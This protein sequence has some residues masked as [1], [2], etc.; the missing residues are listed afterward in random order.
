MTQQLQF[1][2]ST[3]TLQGNLVQTRVCTSA[4]VRPMLRNYIADI[5]RISRCSSWRV[6]TPVIYLRNGRIHL[7]CNV[8]SRV[9][10]AGQIKWAV[11]PSIIHKHAS[12][13]NLK[14]IPHSDTIA[15]LQH[16]C[17]SLTLRV[18]SFLIYFNFRNN[19][20]RISL[21]SSVLGSISKW[22]CEGQGEAMCS[23]MLPRHVR[24]GEERLIKVGSTGGHCVCNHV[25]RWGGSMQTWSRGHDRRGPV[26]QCVLPSSLRRPHNSMAKDPALNKVS[27]PFP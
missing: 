23:I 27:F 6:E 8:L 22:L 11:T 18:L 7:F 16:T 1:F 21:Q 25:T 24:P 26:S 9:H 4:R 13:Y 14:G 2:I 12:T 10:A 20:V 3:D 19:K 15:A 17:L 5:I